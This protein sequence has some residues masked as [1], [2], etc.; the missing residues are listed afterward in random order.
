MHMLVNSQD[1]TQ[2]GIFEAAESWWTGGAWRKDA[3]RHLKRKGFR[4]GLEGHGEGVLLWGSNRKEWVVG[5][6]F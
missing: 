1:L 3:H 2:V 6:P 4:A 5:Q